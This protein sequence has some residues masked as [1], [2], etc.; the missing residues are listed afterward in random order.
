M[1]SRSKPTKKRCTSASKKQ[2]ELE[3]DEVLEPMDDEPKIQIKTPS[4][5][6]NLPF[7]MV[8][9]NNKRMMLPADEEG[10]DEASEISSI[11]CWKPP[12]F[13]NLRVRIDT[14]KI[15]FLEFPK[16]EGTFIVANYEKVEGKKPLTIGTL[17]KGK[18]KQPTVSVSLFNDYD[19]DLLHIYKSQL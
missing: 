13:I 10:D 16:K 1:T 4:K 7:K 15:S 9:G 19:L 6:T 14:T 5:I 18:G 11:N 12:T 3:C 17:W 8:D 2:P